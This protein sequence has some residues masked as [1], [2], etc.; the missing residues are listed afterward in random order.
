MTPTLL[1]L[2]EVAARLRIGKS[3]AYA[4]RSAI[5]YVQIGGGYFVK[6]EDLERFIEKNSHRPKQER[7][8]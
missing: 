8:F 7:P 3:K 5:G 2:R 4:L 1:T 6:E